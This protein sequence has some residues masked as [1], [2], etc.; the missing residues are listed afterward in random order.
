MAAQSQSADP[1]FRWMRLRISEAS[2]G[3]ETEGNWEQRSVANSNQKVNQESIYVVPT[4]GLDMVG[5]I[6]HPNLFQYDIKT[7]NGVGWQENTIDL[8][9]GGTRSDVL[10]LQ[11]Y[12]ANATFLKEKP[13]AVGFTAEKDRTTRDYDF[14]TRATV[15]R[16]SYGGRAGYTEGPV[17]F[18]ISMTHT[19]E[20]ISGQYR[21][22]S[23][24]DDTLAFSAYNERASGDRTD[25][26]YS[27][28]DYTRQ[29]TGAYTQD[30]SQHSASLTD[31]ETFGAK[32]HLRL[33][34]SLQFNQLDTTSTTFG[35]ANSTT[36][37]S[38]T[39]SDHEHLNVK[40]S[41]SLQSD[42]N[43]GYNMQDSGFVTSDGHSGSA[44]LRHQLYESLSS[45]FDAHGQAYSS[46]GAGMSLDTTR[47]GVGLNENYTKRIGK[48][49]RLTLGYGGLFDREHRDTLG[50]TL[51]IVG[52]THTLSDGAITF[53]NQPG[54]NTL[55][56][57][58]WDAAGA[59]RYRELLDYLILP[60]G[61]RT[62]IKR[63]VGGQ[64]PDGASVRVDYSVVSQPS[65]SYTTAAHQFQVRL[66]FFDGMAGIYGHMNLQENYGGKTLLLESINDKVAGVDFT[67]RWLRLGAEY[68]LYDSNL[69]PYRSTRLFQ[70]LNFELDPTTTLNFDVGQT[71][72][73]FTQ[74]NRDLTTYHFIVRTRFQ[75]NPALS[76]NTEG[77]MR[78]QQGEGYDQQ[79]ATARANLEYKYGK[80]A[81]QT[82]YEYEDETFLGEL[83]LRHFFFLRAKRTF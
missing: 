68:E 14:F 27:L 75:I 20:D 71:W 69:S 59:V 81:V 67:R 54:V 62:E 58:V 50:S 32:E 24:T 5:S 10:Y 33:N 11:R 30:G 25:L 60:H 76:L 3:V 26:S 7:E 2:V 45:S 17:P 56:I 16:E 55:S 40:H 47:Y 35:Q 51:F 19:K 8:R 82:G 13:Y 53:L 79:L 64:I 48:W 42:Y 72:R 63:V 1:E 39:F 52:E 80:L 29:E 18:S 28:N 66:D 65:D 38:T 73:T 49:G 83:R 4:V 21:P 23:Q 74:V 37:P 9:G 44:A 41:S 31:H 6:Y 12:L 57:E 77:G 46:R 36:R 78:F 15:D 43:Y 22:L 70:N 34:S 61:D